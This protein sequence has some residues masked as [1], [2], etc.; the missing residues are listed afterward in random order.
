MS[1][2][3]P[4]RIAVFSDVHLG[5]PNTPT[6]EII[7]N[8]E[9]AF[10]DTAETGELDI[11][12]IAGDM[13]DRMLY[14]PDENVGEIK[15]WI[16]RFL[17][18]CKARDIVVRV[19]EGTPSHD[20]GQNR[21]FPAINE[22]GKIGA[23][24][25]YHD[26]LCIEYI[27]RF[28]IHVLYV[29]DEWNFDTD[30]TWRQVQSLLRDHGLTQV[31]FAVMHGAFRYQYPPHVPSPTHVEERYLGIV[32][33]Y[34]FI[35]HVHRHSSYERI[36]APGSFD[37]LCHGEEEPKGHLRV[38]VRGNGQDEIRFVEN[39]GAKIYKTVN[40]S[41]L[42][43]EEAIRR[44]DEVCRELPVGSFVRIEAEREDAIVNSLDTLKKNHPQFHWSTKISNRKTVG[45]DVLVNLQKKYQGVEIRPDNIAK[46]LLERVRQK[47]DDAQ[48]LAR[49][50]ELLNEVI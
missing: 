4:L 32:K 40:C 8:L 28:G 36:L 22:I 14:L 16:N 44:L 50:E 49:C 11:I 37:R 33:H 27:E 25:V 45:D 43:L 30:E 19:L 9:K 23:D 7:E 3:R 24:L 2:D 21:L 6:V 17:R 34:I 38:T 1:P 26:T 35:G 46:L 15:L 20:R 39:T 29:P 18:M 13:F 10:P 31:D 48:V 12:F 47:S 5:H 41:G 42:S